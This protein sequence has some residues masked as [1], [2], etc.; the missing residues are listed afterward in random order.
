MLFY[1]SSRGK[2]LSPTPPDF[3][4]L[5]QRAG[6]RQGH[7]PLPSCA[8]AAGATRSPLFRAAPHTHPERNPQQSGAGRVVP[9][10]GEQTSRGYPAAPVVAQRTAARPGC[11]G[12][13]GADCALR[14]RA[15]RPGGFQA[16]ASGRGDTRDSPPP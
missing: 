5:P 8:L 12:G 10:S 6:A 11:S 7:V 16:P 15:Q 14:F 1:E 3:P 13:R 2:E 4:A 9:R